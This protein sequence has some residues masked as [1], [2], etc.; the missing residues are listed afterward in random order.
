MEEPEGGPGISPVA[1]TILAI[2]LL[3]SLWLLYRHLTA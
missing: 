3:L 2:V 1:V